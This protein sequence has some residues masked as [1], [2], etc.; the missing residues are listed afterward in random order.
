MSKNIFSLIK[1]DLLAA[2]SR[3]PAARSIIEILFT[4][5]G[6]HATFFYRI[7]HILWNVKLK[8]LAR[9][10]SNISRV[11]TSIEI[12]PASKIGEGFFVDHGAG[13][14]IG[15][16][17]ELGNNVTMYQQVTLGGISPSLNSEKQKNQKR[18]P[19]IGNN[20]IIGSGAQL[21]GPINIGNNSRIGANAVVLNDV[22]TNQTYIGIPARKVRSK[23]AISS[24]KPYGIID[25][26]IDDPN[27]STIVGILTE[28]NE[29]S[30]R[31]K[32]LEE[33]IKNFNEKERFIKEN[34]TEKKEIDKNNQF[35]SDE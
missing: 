34:V 21:L 1:T 26:K 14:V 24:F 5:S 29:I 6:F 22:P 20:V 19:T 30:S 28:F 4:Y 7:S 10:L 8:F 2:K 35:G 23:N 9:F 3:D 15:E 12:H 13:L 11:L 33:E 27:K 25:G 18:H 31:I 17:A 16:T 32:Q